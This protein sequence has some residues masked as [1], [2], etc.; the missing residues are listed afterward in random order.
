MTLSG[1]KIGIIGEGFVEWGGGIDFLRYCLRSVNLHKET[2]GFEVVLLLPNYN[3]FSKKIRNLASP[4]KK[5]AKDIL[6][7]SIPQYKR[8][9]LPKNKHILD[10]LQPL[11]PDL[12][13]IFYNS[14]SDLSSLVRKHRIDCVLPCIRP[15]E[16][17]INCRSVNYIFDFQHKY[18][19]EFFSK[20]DIIYRDR[21]FSEIIKTSKAI[22]V[23]ARSVSDDIAKYY[24]SCKAR[25]Y[26]LPFAAAP[27]EN[28]F[29]DGGVDVVSK[30]NLNSE[31]FIISNQ[32]WKHKGHEIAFK[33]LAEFFKII[34]KKD[35][36]I[37]CT[38]KN[39]D[40]RFPGLLDE[41]LENLKA[42]SIQNSVRFLGHIP[43]LDQIQL[44]RH[45]LAVIQPTLFEGGPGGGAAYDAVALGCP[46]ILSD[47]SVNLE[48]KGE[49]G[50]SYFASGDY[51]DLAHKMA[52]MY[53]DRPLRLDTLKLIAAGQIR[54]LS[55]GAKLLEAAEFVTN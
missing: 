25:V 51:V 34:G 53:E 19:P 40:H 4:F 36:L 55:F 39:E 52:K 44:M 33:A 46:A 41:I 16:H 35:V 11:P 54:V 6:R 29:D 45:A 28:W 20:D 24:P 26:S 13:I 48:I 38:G 2:K 14:I 9:A 3:A 10:S 47:I 8:T 27:S 12:E 22:L 31:Y 42:M 43:K 18:Y 5:M 21:M 1:K 32:L 23:N 37:V 17:L 15:I 50:I 30:Y 49:Q 7:L